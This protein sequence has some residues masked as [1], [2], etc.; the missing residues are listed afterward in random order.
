MKKE[1][2][3]NLQVLVTEEFDKFII[4]QKIDNTITV[5]S[6]F[7]KIENTYTSNFILPENRIHRVTQLRNLIPRISKFSS[8]SDFVNL[9]CIECFDDDWF[10]GAES[11]IIM[12]N[13]VSKNEK[14][15]DTNKYENILEGYERLLL[16]NCSGVYETNT[17]NIKNK[18]KFQTSELKVLPV[19]LYDGFILSINNRDKSILY[20]TLKNPKENLVGH[21][22]KRNAFTIVNFFYNVWPI[23][24]INIR[25]K[26]T[27]KL[28]NEDFDFAFEDENP[29]LLKF[30][31]QLNSET[32]TMEK[33]GESV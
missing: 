31:K 33:I 19:L 9:D 7:E 3:K 10:N 28:F 32:T 26:A 5:I 12:L 6:P 4:V 13:L 1:K 21:C 30:T 27:I 25:M 17:I 14:I 16:K 20:I 23:F 22:S 11:G 29:I 18:F 2:R 24:D 15:K 8:Y